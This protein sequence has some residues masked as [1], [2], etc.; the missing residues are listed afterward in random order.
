MLL[1]T[2]GRSGL[3]GGGGFSFHCELFTNAHHPLEDFLAGCSGD[4]DVPH[5]SERLDLRLAVEVRVNAFGGQ[6]HVDAAVNRRAL[7]VC[8]THDV[9]HGTHGVYRVGRAEGQVE[10]GAQVLFEL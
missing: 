6:R 9:D 3:F 2:Q 8:S 5:F 4:G 10:D 7:G 1:R